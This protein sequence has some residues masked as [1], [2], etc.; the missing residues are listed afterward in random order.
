MTLKWNSF[1]P[2]ICPFL[3][4]FGRIWCWH[5][6]DTKMTQKWHSFWLMFVH[7]C[8]FLSIFGPIWCWHENDT[9][10]TQKWHSFLSTFD[11]SLMCV[12]FSN[13]K[14]CW[15]RLRFSI[16]MWPGAAAVYSN[17][18]KGSRR[19]GKYETWTL[20][21]KGRATFWCAYRSARV[22]C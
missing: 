10:M 12:G 8:Q 14:S 19:K 13:C 22:I 7:F 15:T 4:I 1:W 17:M 16:N 9:K 5:E 6:N 11:P 3:S 20:L 18:T 21:K 2:N